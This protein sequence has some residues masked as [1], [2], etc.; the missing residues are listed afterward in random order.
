[1]NSPDPPTPPYLKRYPKDPSVVPED[2]DGAQTLAS[3]REDIEQLSFAASEI[4]SAKRSHRVREHP[5]VTEKKSKYEMQQQLKKRLQDVIRIAPKDQREEKIDEILS[6]SM[7]MHTEEEINQ[8]LTDLVDDESSRLDPDGVCASTASDITSKLLELRRIQANN[9]NKKRDPEESR[10]RQHKQ[11]KQQRVHKEPEGNHILRRLEAMNVSIFH[12]PSSGKQTKDD[13]KESEECV[14]SSSKDPHDGTDSSLMLPDLSRKQSTHR[15]SSHPLPVMHH[16]RNVIKPRATLSNLFTSTKGPNK[17]KPRKEQPLSRDGSKNTATPVVASIEA[18]KNDNDTSDPPTLAMKEEDDLFH[19]TG[20]VFTPARP[21]PHEWNQARLDSIYGGDIQETCWQQDK[22]QEEITFVDESEDGIILIQNER[23][24]REETPGYNKY[25]WETRES[26]PEHEDDHYLGEKQTPHNSR[27]RYDPSPCMET[28][29][30][31]NLKEPEIIFVDEDANGQPKI[32]RSPYVFH[33]SSSQKRGNGDIQSRDY[34]SLFRV[35]TRDD[36]GTPFM[37]SNGQP[38]VVMSPSSTHICE[39]REI[40]KGRVPPVVYTSPMLVEAAKNEAATTPADEASEKKIIKEEKTLVT[41][42]VQQMQQETKQA[43]LQLKERRVS[44]SNYKRLLL[45]L[46]QVQIVD[47]SD[48][49]NDDA[50]IDPSLFKKP[51]LSSLEFDRVVQALGEA[52]VVKTPEL[53]QNDT[54][55]PDLNSTHEHNHNEA[56]KE[57][58]SRDDM[59]EATR[60]LDSTHEH[61]HT[62]EPKEGENRDDMEKSTGE[63]EQR[64]LPEIQDSSSLDSN[65]C[66]RG[67]R[68]K[69]KSKLS[70]PRS[71]ETTEST[72]NHYAKKDPDRK[73][74]QTIDGSKSLNAASH[75]SKKI[76]RKRQQKE[77]RQNHRQPLSNVSKDDRS[78][79]IQAASKLEL[80]LEQVSTDV[81]QSYASSS[82]S[83]SLQKHMSLAA[84]TL[85]HPSTRENRAP[86]ENKGKIGMKTRLSILPDGSS[87]STETSAG[88]EIRVASDNVQSDHSFE[89]SSSNRA[90]NEDKTGVNISSSSTA[91][92]TRKE[93]RTVSD[94]LQSDHSLK[95]SSPNRASIEDKGGGGLKSPLPDVPKCSASSTATSAA[96]EIRA[97]PAADANRAASD[98]NL[99]NLNTPR[100][101]GPDPPETSINILSPVISV[102]SM[103]SDYVPDSI[104]DTLSL[105]RKHQARDP[106][107]QCVPYIQV[108][109]ISPSGSSWI[110]ENE[111]AVFDQQHQLES[112]LEEAQSQAEERSTSSSHPKTQGLE[113]TSQDD[114]PLQETCLSTASVESKATWASPVSKSSIVKRAEEELLQITKS[115]Q[116][117]RDRHLASNPHSTDQ[118]ATKVPES[119]DVGCEKQSNLH[120]AKSP[121]FT[122]KSGKEIDS[123]QP[124]PKP[125][126]RESQTK[127]QDVLVQAERSRREYSS[128]SSFQEQ[129]HDEIQSIRTSKKI[130]HE[131]HTNLTM[132]KSESHD[133]VDPEESSLED[134]LGDE[135]LEDA[136]E[137]FQGGGRVGEPS[138]EETFSTILFEGGTEEAIPWSGA[139]GVEVILSQATDS[140]DASIESFVESLVDDLTSVDSHDDQE[141]VSQQEDTIGETTKDAVTEVSGVY[142]KYSRLTSQA[143]GPAMESVTKYSEVYGKYSKLTATNGNSML[144]KENQ[145]LEN[146]PLSSTSETETQESNNLLIGKVLQVR[147]DKDEIKETCDGGGAGDDDDVFVSPFDFAEFPHLP[148]GRNEKRKGA[149]E[150]SQVHPKPAAES[151]GSSSAAKKRQAFTTNPSAQEANAPKGRHMKHASSHRN[152]DSPCRAKVDLYRRKLEAASKFSIVGNDILPNREQR[153][154]DTESN[155]DQKE[156]EFES[157]NFESEKNESSLSSGKVQV[158]SH[159]RRLDPPEMKENMISAPRAKRKPFGN[160]VQ[161]EKAKPSSVLPKRRQTR[162]LK[163]GAPELP[164]VLP[165]KEDTCDDD[166]I[167]SDGTSDSSELLG[168]QFLGSDSDLEKEKI[169]VAREHIN[170]VRLK[171][172]R[173]KE[174]IAHTEKKKAEAE[175]PIS[176]KPNTFTFEEDEATEPSACKKGRI[177]PNG[178][179]KPNADHPYPRKQN[180]SKSE[181][182]EAPELSARKKERI[183]PAEKKKTNVDHPDS[184][185]PNMPTLQE[186]EMSEPSVEQTTKPLPGDE[187]NTN[188]AEDD[189]T[190]SSSLPSYFPTKLKP[191]SSESTSS[192]HQ[193]DNQKVI[194]NLL[195]STTK[196]SD[197]SSHIKKLR[198]ACSSLSAADP[199]TDPHVSRKNNGASTPT[200]WS[201]FNHGTEKRASN[202]EATE[203]AER[204][205][206]EGLEKM[207]KGLAD[208]KKVKLSLEKIRK[209]RATHSP[210]PKPQV[211][212]ASRAAPTGVLSGFNLFSW[213]HS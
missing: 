176:R 131:E 189:H 65:K 101:V 188:E 18:G 82:E 149:R 161:G 174:R 86:H 112:F 170:Q 201:T 212:T 191:R 155:G 81:S 148:P 198:L 172:L 127:E 119:K 87:S 184:I 109:E 59:E 106:S 133:Y 164:A 1:L 186:D 162:P 140:L 209:K 2:D 26:P 4:A 110:F 90:S 80:C 151:K 99:Q 11:K 163:H 158:Q 126:E 41:V 159:R 37:T 34:V 9:V 152:Q 83:F 17:H 197:T 12:P 40:L 147:H 195:P 128:A 181:E 75:N 204:R 61:K 16:M 62:A 20:A 95:S 50:S 79:I 132:E 165:E 71:N 58:E 22:K 157:G 88:K 55:A 36:S 141:S 8:V 142:G 129:D 145:E 123:R 94:N 210:K 24:D 175:H 138:V 107:P 100:R 156:H 171:M 120:D 23:D 52:R 180:K 116:V 192:N 153:D 196:F 10:S 54:E 122:K 68:P 31:N 29:T 19:R 7:T 93:K 3:I 108:G 14:E 42:E 33:S 111:K 13:G 183:A 38:D 205:V 32:S 187:D 77:S 67:H 92:S 166:R 97:A 30:R 117:L 46:R 207:K 114:E 118:N 103:F 144:K 121:I 85:S 211:S 49:P 70:G 202:L 135:H 53:D 213:I 51:H 146:P 177:A 89:S 173:K 113:R 48:P 45:A 39:T 208:N 35:E 44:R 137:I 193:D 69:H 125:T 84:D 136:E 56:P 78:R 96:K 194:S 76:E 102:V 167:M 182:D 66:I 25:S 74:K 143:K 134:A 43:M 179:K 160:G 64:E 104:A 15:L 124:S 154:Y 27:R 115:L 60:D 150:S 63:K 57:R 178:Q 139:A 28:S 203:R 6:Q 47:H 190:N 98:N 200:S 91:S 199:Y 105:N 206:L 130:R 169:Q 72:K 21:S 5:A 73:P 168:D 185:K